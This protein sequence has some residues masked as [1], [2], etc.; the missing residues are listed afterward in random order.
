MLADV[1]FVPSL[2]KVKNFVFIKF[3]FPKIPTKKNR[4]LRPCA[5]I[6]T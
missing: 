4:A 6:P 1:K 5:H 3:L 2:G